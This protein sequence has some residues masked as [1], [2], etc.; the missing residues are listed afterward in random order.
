MRR[1][2]ERH[3]RPLDRRAPLSGER[4]QVLLEA[5]VLAVFLAGFFG[6]MIAFTE[7][8]RGRL[9][10]SHWSRKESTR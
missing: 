1:H 5:L 4:G 2:V 3:E 7:D 9:Q 6:L 8:T 10:K